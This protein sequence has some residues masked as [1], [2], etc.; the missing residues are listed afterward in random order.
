MTAL[1]RYLDEINLRR[2]LFGRAPLDPYAD[3][4]EVRI[5]VEALGSPEILAGDGEYSRAETQR[6]T[7]EWIDAMLA[8]D[9]IGEELTA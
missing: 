3:Y 4:W 2:S 6:R 8:L 7:D 5:E 1:T 9:E